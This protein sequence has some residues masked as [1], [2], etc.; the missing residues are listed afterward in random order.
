MND[1]TSPTTV[2][3][4]SSLA[5]RKALEDELLEAFTAET[6]IPVDVSFDPTTEIAR[7]IEAGERP[8]VLIAVSSSLDALVA[9]GAVDPATITPLVRTRV[10][11]AV[12]K[13]AEQPNISTVDAFVQT[14]LNARSVAYSEAGA[15]GI[16]LRKLL[17]HLGILD[18]VKARATV[19]PKGF[20]ATAIIDGRADVA[21]QQLSEL[22]FV[23][24]VDIVGPLP[25]EI[26]D[27]TEFSGALG[28][29]AAQMPKAAALLRFLA[30]DGAHDAY[31]RSG[32]EPV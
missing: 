28:V 1:T 26:E 21:F 3:F 15:S 4:T 6:G 2:A 22:A 32:V 16:Y 11:I 5:T 24:G 18:Q 20:T 17:V 25:T 14:M 12:A 7:R 27:V 31:R 13:G 9:A 10:G 8:D 29:H 23:P 30:G 19:L